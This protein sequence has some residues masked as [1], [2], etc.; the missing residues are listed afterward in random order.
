MS[1]P[2][3]NPR[4][5]APV[6]RYRAGQ[7]P[8]N[9]QESSDEEEEDEQQEQ[10][11]EPP[12]IQRRDHASQAIQF[13][14][15]EVITGVEQ[16]AISDQDAASDRRLRRLK[17]AQEARADESGRRRRRFEEDEPAAAQEE[18]EDE[19]EIAAQRQRMKQKALELRKAQEAESS[20][21]Q[22]AMPI[23]EEEEDEEE[24]EGS[25]EYETDSSEDYVAPKLIKPVFIPKDRRATVMEKERIAEAE[26][27]AE[28]QRLERLEQRKVESHQLLADQLKKDVMGEEIDPDSA[29]GPPDVDDTDGV[30]EEAEFEAWK[31][32]ELLR[33]KRDKEERIARDREREEIERRREMPE[34][35]RLKED[36]ERARESRKKERSKHQFM[37]KYYHKGAFYQD[38][39]DE[40]FK[41]D[42]EVATES[43]INKK[44]M[45]PEVMQVKKFGMAGQTKYKHLA[46]EDT[47]DKTSAW[48]QKS[49]VNRRTMKRM[50]GM[51]DEF[52][53]RNKR[54]R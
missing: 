54:R 23:E 14:Q 33:I 9:V 52:E 46:A 45:L 47:T 2:R 42:Y 6:K 3:S 26:E 13:A 15:K 1:A 38:N 40:I 17:E 31:I 43:E 27:A 25:T 35:E 37:Q 44:E 30:D 53:H 36:L 28:R 5:P 48:M 34:E 39:D 11:Q 21:L 8:T 49:D 4:L 29:A 7:A 24:E 18:S 41:R 51:K 20:R 10:Q 19:D 12:S 32:R 16:V 50:G 22:E